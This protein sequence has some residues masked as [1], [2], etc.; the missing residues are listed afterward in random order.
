MRLIPICLLCQKNYLT[1]VTVGN[2]T[3]LKLISIK[4]IIKKKKNIIFFSVIFLIKYIWLHWGRQSFQGF[5]FPTRPYIV[6]Y[7]QINIGRNL[8]RI[9]HVC[10]VI[11]WRI[12]QLVYSY[13]SLPC[14]IKKTGSILLG[15]K[16]LSL[17]IWSAREVFR[18]I[19]SLFLNIDH[20]RWVQALHSFCILSSLHFICSK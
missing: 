3:N 19:P 4:T 8:W 15:G 9:V 10:P 14:P 2:Y 6:P 5:P 18:G 13:Q 1:I 17:A 7:L 16:S 12:K 20:L 11:V